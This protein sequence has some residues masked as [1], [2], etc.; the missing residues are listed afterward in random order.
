MGYLIPLT[1]QAFV[2][3]NIYLY[4]LAISNKFCTN[5]IYISLLQLTFL[6]HIKSRISQCSQQ[7]HFIFGAYMYQ[8]NNLY[9]DIEVPNDLLDVS[10]PNLFIENIIFTSQRALF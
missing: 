2:T 1:P 9:A 10:F 4:K 3:Y 8:I 6:H 7:Y 5:Y